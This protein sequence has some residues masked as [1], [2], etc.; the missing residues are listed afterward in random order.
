V[1]SLRSVTSAVTVSV[2]PQTAFAAFTDEMDLWWVRGPI[3]FFDSARAVKMVCEQGVGGRILEMYR[4]DP[5]DAL[6][7]AR[8]TAW[9]PGRLLAW[10][11]SVDDVQVEVTFTPTAGG[12]TVRVLAT[13]PVG[14]QDRGGTAWQ[15][16]VPD[17]FGAWCARR[18]LVVREPEELDRLA[19]A[20][21][22]RKPVTAARWL[23]DAFGFT[24]PRSLP[25][26]MPGQDPADLEAER[27]WL[28][29]RI[30][31]CSLMLFRTEA[32][33]PEPAT[34]T[35]VPWIFVDDLDAHFAHA[36]ATG[37]KIVEAIHQ[38]GYRAY[39]AEDPEGHR[40]IFAQARPTMR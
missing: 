4:T 35:H 20:V 32:D 26:P 29:F 14:G 8:I 30:G 5:E 38:H 22:Y 1:T 19:I 3:N 25:V 17:F 16:V 2:S 7:L 37:A 13:V 40:W 24:S 21:Y 31:H 6:E 36:N 12:T 34:V 33:R 27:V 28:E 18:D 9:E 23:S 39:Q 10:D 11:S 15:R